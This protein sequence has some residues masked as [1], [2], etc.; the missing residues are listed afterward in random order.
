MLYQNYV[1]QIEIFYKMTLN[2]QSLSL[3]F[4][5]HLGVDIELDRW[6]CTHARCRAAP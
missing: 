4:M 2:T 1:Y 5:F 6:G 3:D